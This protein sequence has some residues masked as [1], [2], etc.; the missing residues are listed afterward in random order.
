[1]TI[2][3]LDSIYRLCP[4][5][6]MARAAVC[7]TIFCAA[8]LVAMAACCPCR[9]MAVA[10]VETAD[11]V[12]VECRTVR[13]IVR[14]TVV[15]ALPREA[16]RVVVRDTVSHLETSLAESDARIN[17]D[18]SLT[19]TLA[20][21][22]TGLTVEVAHEVE[23]RDSVVWRDRVVTRQVEVVRPLTRRQRMQ[24]VG[25]WVLAVLLTVVIWLYVRRF[26]RRWFV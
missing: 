15:V 9:R 7:S 20:N 11:S 17:P 21:R 10:A 13:E 19:H 25:F 3:Y 5:L 22:R 6:R 12:R 8:C 18:G 23:R 4:L 2:R 1:M 26:V 14:D 16:E 24:I